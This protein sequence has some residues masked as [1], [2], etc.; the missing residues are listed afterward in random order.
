MRPLHLQARNLRTWAE[1][2]LHL[3]RGVCAVV[4]ENGAG[5]STLVQAIDLALFAG[6]G[7]L[8]RQMTRG[9]TECS[10]ELVF[11]HGHEVYRVR[12]SY[13]A[14]GGGKPRLDL[15][16]EVQHT[17]PGTTW[18]PLTRETI[19]ATEDLLGDLLGLSRATYRASSYLAQGEGDAFTAARPAERKAILLEALGVR[20]WDELR[21]QAAADLRAAEREVAT[22]VG[23]LD[24]AR[25]EAKLEEGA[26]AALAQAEFVHAEREA[27]V[28]DL[29]R[30]LAERQAE[31]QGLAEL[32]AAAEA[33]QRR[34]DDLRAQHAELAERHA[35]LSG[36]ASAASSL[37]KRLAEAR[38]LCSYE[39]RID[40]YVA[41][42]A[43][44]QAEQGHVDRLR[45]EHEQAQARQA[46]YEAQVDVLV[47]EVAE[48]EQQVADPAAACHACG[49]DLQGE[50]LAAWQAERK[51]ELA[52]AATARD[53][54]VAAARGQAVLAGNVGQQ[55]AA[56]E[57]AVHAAEHAAAEAATVL[58][59]DMVAAPAKAQ[60]DARTAAREVS[61]LEE[62][63]AG[64]P[65]DEQVAQA[66]A[67]AELVQAELAKA[68]AAAGKG[69]EARERGSRAAAAVQQATTDL[70][71]RRGELATAAS[72]VVRYQAQVE[73]LAKVAA[74]AEHL[75]L[76]VEQGRE[77]VG[78]HE[79]EVR[80]YG[81]D[82][83]PALILEASALPQLE[84]EAN[85]L[86]GELGRPYRFSLRSTRTTQAGEQREALDIVVHTDAGEAQYEDFSGGERT[87]LDLA[88]RIAL[89][90]LL[91][92]RRG[93][94]VQVLAIDE[95]AYLDAEGFVRLAGALRT[96]APEFG[97]VLVVS[98][99]AELR[100]A[101]D[102]VL[103][104]EGGADTGQPSQLQ[105]VQP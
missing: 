56:H 71:V 42:V 1:L 37:R 3:P 84:A 103:T 69:A 61:G 35:E 104:V 29:E 34:A 46:E 44:R 96:L 81:R 15:E 54:A 97:T 60:Q 7:E 6:R 40:S 90:R 36:K 92:A 2:D 78:L 63:L 19:A 82:G 48:L 62:R 41:A 21:A 23:R 18:E 93:A 9:A 24:D 79:H 5:K 73:Q 53:K 25:A 89:A 43:D 85:A 38:L 31:A 27:A 57:R 75:E 98:H 66:K 28:A 45:R 102:Q 65:S 95:P 47:A 87:R 14:K 68:E 51:A 58:P 77:L 55:L 72:A 67:A 22:L 80:A 4:G 52:K 105:E 99:V 70:G 59:D 76:Q 50:A 30:G 10:V 64:L 94:D 88:L 11:Q 83:V 16:R 8:A 26:Q 39:A 100:D 13:E 12:R 91:A 33:E 101:F 20:L 86:V 74:K 17:E 49:Q 32:A